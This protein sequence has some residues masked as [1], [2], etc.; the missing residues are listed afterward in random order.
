MEETIN[1]QII[2]KG[3][4]IV[5]KN[6]AK[7]SLF[8]KDKTGRRI[9][10]ETPI[11]YYTEAYKEWAK[12]AIQTCMV[13]KTKNKH[14]KF[15]ITEKMNLKCLFFLPDTRRVD[16]SALY[17]GI[18]D[19]LSGNEKWANVNAELYQI[20]FDDSVRYIGSH[21]GSRALLDLTNPRM[22]ITLT[23]YKI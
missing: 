21:D 10:R 7:T 3:C 6:N 19:V 11:H 16:L 4:P 17:E 13:Y 1:I 12:G 22:E 20:I 15:P 5:K 9:A 23:N 2:I 14:I 18:Q 8:S